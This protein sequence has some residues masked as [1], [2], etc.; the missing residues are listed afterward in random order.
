MKAVMPKLGQKIETP[1]GAGTV[2]SLQLLKGLVTIL[3]DG[4]NQEQTFPARELGFGDAPVAPIRIEKRPK[5]IV[6]ETVEVDI[7]EV[8]AVAPAAEPG[9]SEIA[10][11][12]Q[13]TSRGG[14][15]RRRRRNRGGQSQ[16][17]PS[18]SNGSETSE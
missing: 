14:K 6:Q 13:S 18:A 3:P 17:E 9:E 16:G 11:E 4:E 1:L 12:K 7:V 5:E 10:D 15:R 8:E 2:V